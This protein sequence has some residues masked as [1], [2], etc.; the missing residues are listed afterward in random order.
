MICTDIFPEV[1][2][3]YASLANISWCQA[4][5]ELTYIISD[6]NAPITSSVSNTANS[7]AA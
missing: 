6:E 7:A 1:I 2:S 5:Q 4:L 3:H